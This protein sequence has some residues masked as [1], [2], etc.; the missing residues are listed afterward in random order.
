[1]SGIAERVFEEITAC[2]IRDV[3]VSMYIHYD[4][5][6]AGIYIN[7]DFVLE[8]MKNVYGVLFANYSDY[9]KLIDKLQRYYLDNIDKNI[10]LFLDVNTRPSIDKNKYLEYFNSINQ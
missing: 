3:V 2:T 6:S 9:E 8:T 4:E 10:M 7:E 5:R 1:M